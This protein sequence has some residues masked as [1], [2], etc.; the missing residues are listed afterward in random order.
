MHDHQESPDRHYRKV[1]SFVRRS[2]RMNQSQHKSW[3]RWHDRYVLDL[4][5]GELETQLAPQDPIDLLAAF[6][7]QAPLA[8]EIGSGSG[9]N[10]AAMALEH[11]DWN[12]L[13]FEVFEPAVA[14]TFV[15]LAAAEVDNVR[16]VVADGADGLAQL[17]R[18]G[19][20]QEL[21]TYFPD[22][23]HKVRHHKRRL[24]NTDFATLVASRLTSQGRW[25]LA[26]DWDRYAEAMRE[27]LD[28]HPG[29]VNDSAENGWA[30]RFPGRPLTRFEQRGLD[31]G[32]P[33]HD[34]CYRR[35]R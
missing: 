24:V 12:L 18:P 31:A 25:R 22:P 4:P 17:V 32:R 23:W 20:L 10:L 21:W 27:V 30:P 2:P 33:V 14:R 26:T 29:L 5:Q 9:E 13:A 34:L 19:Q 6:G 11:P 7:R 16:I 28:H 3:Q 1:V 35:V 15:R 8:V